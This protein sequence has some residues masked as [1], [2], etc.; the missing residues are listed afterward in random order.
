MFF[1]AIFKIPDKTLAQV[2]FQ[3]KLLKSQM[4]FMYRLENVLLYVVVHGTSSKGT[5]A[6][7]AVFQV[8]PPYTW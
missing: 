4:F 8:I 7:L 1:E 3:Y 2:I 6:A 5:E